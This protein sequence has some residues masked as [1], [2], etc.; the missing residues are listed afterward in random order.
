[1]S[2]ILNYVQGM[3]PPNWDTTPSGWTHGNC[4]MCI[5]NGES[6]PDEK[7]R[8]GFTF[9]E[10]GFVYNCFN[11]GYKVVYKNGYSFTNRLERLM[12]G[13]GTQDSDIQ[14]LKLDLMREGDISHLVSNTKKKKTLLYDWKEIELPEDAKPLIQW[15]EVD[16]N[17]ISA[18]Q[19]LEDRGFDS[20]DERFMYSKTKLNGRMNKRFIIPFTYK[21][22]IVGYTARWI[23]KPPEGMPK[24]FNQ[25]PKNDYVY[26]IDRQTN[27]KIVI[28][29]EGQLDAIITDGVAIGSNKINDSQAEIIESLADRIIVLPDFDS[30]GTTMVDFAISRKWEVSFPEWDDCKDAGDALGKYGRLYTI[31]SIIDSSQGNKVKIEMLKRKF[32][33]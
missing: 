26:G 12:K 23:G 29:T 7:R 16:D 1:M 11:C 9:D 25:S 30:A 14:R 5:L 13:F 18:I 8:G 21:N 22:K 15:G 4:P 10:D 27:K 33:K 31:R 6:R 32:C 28:V 17:I 2:V 19:Y 20:S 3:I 24:Y